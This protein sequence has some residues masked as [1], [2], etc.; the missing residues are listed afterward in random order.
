MPK[1]FKLNGVIHTVYRGIP[2]ISCDVLLDM[3]LI[4][5]V[6]FSRGKE[7]DTV[8]KHLINPFA[9]SPLLVQSF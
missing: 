4:P 9:S 3:F 5:A 6:T 8:I 2:G 1:E 7:G